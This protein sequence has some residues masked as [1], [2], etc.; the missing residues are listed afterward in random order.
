M[1]EK[2]ARAYRNGKG[3]AYKKFGRF[4][5]ELWMTLQMHKIIFL[6][7]GLLYILCCGVLLYYYVSL[8]EMR[9]S[10][11]YLF[12]YALDFVRLGGVR[13][14]SSYS[15]YD[16]VTLAGETASVSALKFFKCAFISGGVFLL[17]IP[18]LS[19]FMRK[20]AEDEDIWLDGAKL[21]TPDETNRLMQK[22]KDTGDIPLAEIRL[23]RRLETYHVL[24]VGQ[25]GVGKTVLHSHVIDAVIKRNDR[26][27][28]HDF[29]GDYTSIYYNESNSLIFNPLDSRH[30][31]PYGGW[32][33]F[34]EIKTKMDID[35]ISASLIPNGTG[36][37]IFFNGGARDIFSG[38]LH[39]LYYNNMKTNRHIWQ[40]VSLPPTDLALLLKDTKDGGERGYAYLSNPT[41]PMAQSV[42]AVMMQYTKCFEYMQDTNGDFCIAD[43]LKDEE[44][45]Y[46]SIFVTNY[47]D[48]HE[49][50]RPIL[51]LFFDI[52]SSR[53]LS[54]R[55][56]L[57]RRVFFILDEFPALQQLSCIE[58]LLTRGR[59]KG[60]SVFLAI[61]TIMQL[62]K[63]YGRETRETII[64]DCASSITFR[65]GSPETSEYLSKKIGDVK[66]V[67]T[68]ENFVLKIGSKNDG[69]NINRQETVERLILPAT[70]QELDNLNCYVKIPGYSTTR[71]VLRPKKYSEE[72]EP[73]LM[74]P[75]LR[76]DEIIIVQKKVGIAAHDLKKQV[77]EQLARELETTQG[78]TAPLD[79]K[80]ISA[81]RKDFSAIDE[82]MSYTQ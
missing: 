55:E 32:G 26:I 56:K 10:L 74:R 35:M 12:A 64:D 3:A 72:T 52:Q 33:L 69:V 16:I 81:L 38:I 79:I 53:L 15:A 78:T 66:K 41:T 18:I 82:S 23:P 63:I 45:K 75:G 20:D 31:K 47:Q 59:S 17:Y 21:L 49:T 40:T 54:M 27:L 43:W 77:N 58:G 62:D 70:I 67:K 6:A 71:T 73:F 25:L 30:L 8:A 48:I 2:R 22:N 4:Y 44:H 34:N 57:E 68:G 37:D 11:L 51:S 29:K 24:S 13:I 46:K 9:L 36:K 65:V 1:I 60:A 42:L 39:F 61:Q 5:S 80:P 7:L 19:H 28:C 76:L 14:Y 50:L